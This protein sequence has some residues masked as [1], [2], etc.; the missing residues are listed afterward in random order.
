[1]NGL[2]IL[3]VPLLAAVLSVPGLAEHARDEATGGDPAKH[4][5]APGGI[6]D[7]DAKL[8]TELFSVP[9]TF[10]RSRFG[11]TL[12]PAIDEAMSG[13]ETKLSGVLGELFNYVN[14]EQVEAIVSRVKPPYG[15]G[16]RRDLA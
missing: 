5:T 3:V 2:R 8:L 10:I 12:V 14:K 1:M 4:A 16:F 7:R 6:K 13:Q 15:E 11:E 9:E